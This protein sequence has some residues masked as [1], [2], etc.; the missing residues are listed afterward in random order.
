M[1]QLNLKQRTTQRW[2][3]KR[4][5]EDNVR[6]KRGKIGK[7]NEAVKKRKRN[8]NKL[9]SNPEVAMTLNALSGIPFISW[10]IMK[11]TI[12]KQQPTIKGGNKHINYQR[13]CQELQKSRIKKL[14]KCMKISNWPFI[15]L[16]S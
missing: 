6:M 11:D 12:L 2:K 15:F 4:G 9:S 7:K 13:N 14:N 8:Q 3:K 1:S 5:R 16:I 10:T